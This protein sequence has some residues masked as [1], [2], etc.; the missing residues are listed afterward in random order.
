MDPLTLFVE[1]WWVAPAAVG[2]G[3]AGWAGLR[4][5]RSARARRLELD[6]AR[7]DVVQARQAL[8][9]A[10]A[11]VLVARAGVARAEADRSAARAQPGTVAAARA[12]V[13]RA[14]G[15]ARAAWAD[16]RARRADIRAARAA[17]PASRAGREHLPL[18][19]LIARH[20]ALTAR[21]LAYETDP[22]LRIDFP[23]MTDAAQP[24]TAEYLRA[25]SAAQWLRPSSPDARMR[26]AQFAAYR[27]A[28]R[29][30]EH[31]FEV[32]ERAARGQHPS[33]SREGGAERWAEIAREVADT[34]SRAI[35]LSAEAVA[36]AAAWRQRKRPPS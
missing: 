13:Q 22:G 10:R 34:T 9:R 28:V 16:L 5:R 8:S 12:A 33:T 1:A 6:A 14:E 21:W 25:Q 19:R 4:S 23:A 3:A 15:E 36:R 20:D 11:D 2:A 7:H 18:P 35:A 17:L 30:A 31:A 24:T 27:D 32:A 26:P 29:R